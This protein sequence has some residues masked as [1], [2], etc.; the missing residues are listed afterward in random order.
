M[1]GWCG[2]RSEEVGGSK[3]GR[4]PPGTGF[5]AYPRVVVDCNATD[6]DDDDHTYTH[7]HIHTYIHTYITTLG[8]FMIFLIMR[9]L[10]RA[11]QNITSKTCVAKTLPFSCHSSVH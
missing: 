11:A 4:W 8:I 6:D 3:G 10:K 1:D 5:Y 7:T 9:Y 2:G